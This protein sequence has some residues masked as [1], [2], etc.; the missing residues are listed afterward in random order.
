[1]SHAAHAALEAMKQG[2]LPEFTFQHWIKNDIETVAVYEI[3]TGLSFPRK[4]TLWTGLYTELNNIKAM[5]LEKSE[6][7]T[8]GHFADEYLRRR[9]AR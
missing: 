3:A 8:I 1:M 6:L 5:M 4:G 9:L 7:K 2:Q